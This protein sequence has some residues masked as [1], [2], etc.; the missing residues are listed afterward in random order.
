MAV[1]ANP[2]LVFTDGTTTVTVQDGSG[3]A[4]NYPLVRRGWAPAIAGLRA[5]PLAGQTPYDDVTEQMTIEVNGPT[6]AN[7]LANLATLMKLLE[8]AARWYRGENETAVLVK[9]APHG[10]TVSSTAAPLQAAILGGA[11]GPSDPGLRLT[12]EWD[13]V[14]RNYVIRNVVVSFTRRGLWLHTTTEANSPAAANNGELVTFTLTARD[15]KCPT[16]LAFTNFAQGW[17]AGERFSAPFV[18]VGDAVGGS[19]PI[20]IVNAEGGTATAYTSVN[21]SLNARNT[22]VLRFTPTNTSERQSGALLPSLPS[23]TRLVAIFANVLPSTT[24]TFKVRARIDSVLQ[25]QY[26]PYVVIPT[27]AN[28]SA[29]WIFLGIVPISGAINNAY[30]F[31]TADA[32]SSSLDIDTLVFADAEAVQVVGCDSADNPSGGGNYFAVVTGT[33][34]ID[35][36][37]LTKPTPSF[38]DGSTPMLAKGDL[39]IMTKAASV[40]AVLLGTGGGS[41]ASKGYGNFRQ[42]DTSDNVLQN[43]WTATR[44]TAYLVPQ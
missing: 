17:G 29:H 9:F 43:T 42:S 8:Q 32:A 26:T 38:V 24:V 36:R 23:T 41:T 35:H 20:A 10:S 13:E 27:D 44:S 22:N 15:V 3:G 30:L 4:T 18:L 31:I 34:T 25:A 33:G 37:L 14:G 2:Y 12:P 21:P 7:A 1:Q 28:Q 5:S 11:A 40:Y 16:K 39:T 19:A 6:A